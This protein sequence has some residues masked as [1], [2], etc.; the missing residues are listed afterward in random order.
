MAFT[1][2]FHDLQTLELVRDRSVSFHKHDLLSWNAPNKDY[3][4]IVCK[5]LL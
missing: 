2:I 1:F 5:T 4:L 3:G